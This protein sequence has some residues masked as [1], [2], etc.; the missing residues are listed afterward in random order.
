MDQSDARKIISEGFKFSES[1]YKT[2]LAITSDR[3]DLLV[4]H[5][6]KKYYGDYIVVICIATEI[7]RHY[8]DLLAKA[9]IKN[10][11][12]ENILTD[13]GP[14]KNE[15]ADFVYLLPVQYVKGYLN[16]KTG[17]IL[18]NHIFNPRYNS[19]QFESN[20]LRIKNMLKPV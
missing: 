10:L 6:D 3:L 9:G 17:E 2:A 13:Q 12:I 4:K 18:N 5:N 16:H 11:S 7:V 14:V 20:I 19:V 15:N 8:N 1:F